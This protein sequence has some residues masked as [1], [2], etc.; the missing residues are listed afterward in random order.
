[1]RIVGGRHRGVALQAPKGDRTRPTSDRLR[2]SLF[3]ILMHRYGNVVEGARV[4]DL[5]AGTGAL[6]LE[7]LSRGASFALF[8][9]TGAEQRAVI[10][11]NIDAIGA[12][13]R[14]RVWRRDATKPGPCPVAP[15]GLVFADPPYGCGLGEAALAA[16]AADGWLLAGALAIL[17]ERADAL[18]DAI[19]GFRLIEARTFG[20]SAVA[21]LEATGPGAEIEPPAAGED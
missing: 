10:R 11:R 9:E 4:L 15:F 16:V 3:N 1:M 2:E 19:P 21:I 7:A 8:V 5:F 18:P 17:E 20:D 13:G 6:G 14:T 12:V